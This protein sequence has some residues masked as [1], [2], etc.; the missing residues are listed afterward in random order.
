MQAPLIGLGVVILDSLLRREW[1]KEDELAAD[2][3]VHPRI[4]RKALRWFEQVRL[5]ASVWLAGPARHPL[6]GLTAALSLE[7]IFLYIC[8]QIMHGQCWNRALCWRWTKM[9][10]LI[11][12]LQEQLVTREHRKE[13]RKRKTAVKASGTPDHGGGSAASAA[14]EKDVVM[15]NADELPPQVQHLSSGEIRLR[16]SPLFIFS[17]KSAG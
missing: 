5:H 4:L 15:E 7:T 16:T 17:N 9:G 6:L 1:V 12:T 3:K 14:A 10:R 2:L 11:G 13:A 8:L